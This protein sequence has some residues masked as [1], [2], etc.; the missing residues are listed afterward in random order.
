MNEAKRTK[1]EIADRIKD[2]VENWVIL[3]NK[4]D[5][6]DR[7]ELATIALFHVAFSML[8]NLSKGVLSLD[9]ML[10]IEEGL[11]KNINNAI[12]SGILENIKDM[13]STVKLSLKK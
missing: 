2:V 9:S 6:T 8:H 7:Y 10:I 1:R 13:K 4:D 11:I 12:D 5:V 3:T